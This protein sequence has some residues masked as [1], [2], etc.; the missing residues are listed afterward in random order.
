MVINE[1]EKLEVQ[2]FDK[3]DNKFTTL[4][5]LNF[6]WTTS[7]PEMKEGAIELLAIDDNTVNLKI[8]RELN[9][10]KDGFSTD[11]FFRKKKKY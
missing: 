10:A 6:K 9:G 4:A 5:G 7:N 2:A 1:L 3:D 11:G 8:S